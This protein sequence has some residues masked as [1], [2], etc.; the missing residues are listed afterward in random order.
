M[1][2]FQK[3]SLLS[4][5]MDVEQDDDNINT[6]CNKALSIDKIYLSHA[7]MPNG[8]KLRLLKTAL[9]SACEN[10]CYYCAFRAGRDFRR[11]TFVPDE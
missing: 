11:I 5:H 4:E 9:S 6:T 10:N 3:L 7:M 1:D 2:I 8:K